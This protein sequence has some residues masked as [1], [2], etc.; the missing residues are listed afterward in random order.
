ML[1]EVDQYAAAASLMPSPLKL[2]DWLA[3]TFGAQIVEG[4]RA[5]ERAAAA[6]ERGAPV[7]LEAVSAAHRPVAALPDAAP[8]VPSPMAPADVPAPAPVP[9]PKRRF[10]AV[11]LIAAVAVVAAAAAAVVMAGR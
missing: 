8:S 4:R 7:V 9:Q 5:R 3:Q 2:G 11:A 1:R 10:N 6:L